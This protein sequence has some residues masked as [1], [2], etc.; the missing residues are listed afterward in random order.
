MNCNR[1]R[2]WLSEAEEPAKLPPAME[3]HLNACTEC[4]AWQRRLARLESAVRQLP[5]P[6]TRARVEFLCQFLNA[7]ELAGQG[8][9][10]GE[11]IG[12]LADLAETLH[13]E[14]NSLVGEADADGLRRIAQLYDQVVRQG[15]L[16]TAREVPVA[17]RRQVINPIVDLLARTHSDLDCMAQTLPTEASAPLQQIAKAAHEGD[18]ELRALIEGLDSS[19]PAETERP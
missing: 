14:T 13:G 4:Q 18:D 8:G 3:A 15:I 10:P 5:L 12:A 11:R 16:T 1:L 6:R 9:T 2:K 7:G 17:E 19:T